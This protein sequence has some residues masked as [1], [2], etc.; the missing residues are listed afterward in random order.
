MDAAAASASAAVRR[1][2]ESPDETV[3]RRLHAAWA[4]MQQTTN[5]DRTALRRFRRPF[6]T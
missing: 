4:C 6:S 3:L 5:T 1:V 2:L